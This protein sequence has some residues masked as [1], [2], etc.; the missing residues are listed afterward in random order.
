MKITGSK[1]DAKTPHVRTSPSRSLQ[2]ISDVPSKTL[3]DD[4]LIKEMISGRTRYNASK[5]HVTDSRFVV[6][7]DTCVTASNEFE[8]GKGGRGGNPERRRFAKKRGRKGG[9]SVQN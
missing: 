4:A 7:V 2:A 5:K 8:G 3:D 9:R 1:I 6:L